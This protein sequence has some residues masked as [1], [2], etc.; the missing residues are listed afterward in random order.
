[1]N[2]Q[3][4]TTLM[5]KDPIEGTVPNNYRAITFLPL[6]WKIPRAQIR[7]GIYNSLIGRGLFSEELKGFGKW[8][9]GTGELLYIDQHI[10]NESKTGR[11]NL[12]MACIDYK[13]VY[14][15]VLQ[16]WVIKCQISDEFINF[17]EKTMETLIVEL[18]AGG[19]SL[20]E[21]NIQICIFQGDAL[22]SLLFVIAM[23]PLNHV[24]RK[25]TSGYK[26][27]KS[28]EKVNHQMYMDDI[29]LFA[30]KQKNKKELETLI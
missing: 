13:T 2:D 21:A 1:M 15:M 17:T 28:K 22:S 14:D 26:L 4:K 20:T 25:C 8:T 16:S 19:I 18:K 30:K 6:M 10:L 27:G 9:R 23:M 7:E 29:E 5:Q 24:P 3:R 11:K 12:A